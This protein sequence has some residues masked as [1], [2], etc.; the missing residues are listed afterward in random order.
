[1]WVSECDIAY[2]FADG[3]VAY[4]DIPDPLPF[5]INADIIDINAPFPEILF[6]FVQCKL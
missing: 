5:D 4:D 1:M 6:D 3:S 2:E